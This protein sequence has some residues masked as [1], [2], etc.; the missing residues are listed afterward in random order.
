MRVLPTELP[1]V[2]V[3]EPKVFGDD[4]GFFMEMF[5]AKRYADAGI[6]G[7]FVQDNYSRSAKGTL[8]GLHF[9]EPQAQG[10]LVQVIA[11]AVYDVAVDVR[12]GSP[13]FGK[14]VAVELSSD[15]RRQLW[16]PPGFAHGFCVLSESADFHY[17]CTTLYAPETE[18]GVLWND[19]DLAIPWPV[20]SPL[21]SAKDAK[22]PRL[23]DAMVLPAYESP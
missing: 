8:R 23:R 22:A 6:P 9:Q 16:I 19:P 11:G 15:N 13:G 5:H 18:R 14:W 4:R 1:G 7:P 20:T 3:V 12:R 17:K 2:L 10:K 21:L